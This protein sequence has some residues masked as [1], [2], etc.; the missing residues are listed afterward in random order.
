MKE[1]IYTIPVNEAFESD[2]F[3]PLCQL[4]LQLE[5]SRVTYT[6]GPSMMEPDS[7][8]LTNQNGFCAHHYQML[9]RETNKLSLALIL[10]THLESL[11]KKLDV[12]SAPMCADEKKRAGLFRSKSSSRDAAKVFTDCVESIVDKCC[13]C[14][15]VDATMERYLDVLYDLWATDASFREKLKAC[16][17]FCLPHYRLLVERA[18]DY[19]KESQLR[20]FWQALYQKQSQ[21]LSDM[22]SDIHAFTL[23]FDYR[24]KDMPWG[25]AANA[26]QRTVAL[27]S[28]RAGLDEEGI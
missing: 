11:R 24:N 16:R 22:Q 14:S 6:L 8:M 13:I 17:G 19:L 5:Q 15:Y 26:P 20:P 28:G 2:C 9:L 3:C 10:D 7:R 4:R 12:A 18:A 1:T 25:N 21:L 27:L 23:K